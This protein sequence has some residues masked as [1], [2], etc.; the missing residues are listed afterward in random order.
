MTAESLYDT[1]TLFNASYKLYVIQ[2]FTPELKYYILIIG[3]YYI[4]D[5]IFVLKLI[6]KLFSNSKF[7]F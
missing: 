7:K 3:I 1:K 2:Y 5:G 6:R 4:V